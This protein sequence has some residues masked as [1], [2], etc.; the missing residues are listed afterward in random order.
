MDKTRA[1]N[2]TNR[3][4]RVTAAILT[5]IFL[6]FV[7]TAFGVMVTGDFQGLRKSVQLTDEK[8]EQLPGGAGRLDRL[9]ARINGFTAEIADAMW[10]KTELGYANSAFQYALGKRMINTGSQNMVKLNTGHLYDLNPYKD[11]SKNCADIISLRDTALKD[12]PFLFVYEHPTLYAEGMMPAGYEA[13]DASARMADEAAAALREGG[14]EVLDSRDVIPNCGRDLNDLLLVTDQHWSTLA[15]ITMAQSVA[16][17]LNRMTGAKLDAS[18]LDLENLNTLK[19]EKLFIGKYGQRLGPGLVTPDDI[20]EYWPKADTHIHRLTRHVTRVVEEDGPFR[21][22]VTRFEVLETPEGQSWN[23]RAYMLYGLTESYS[24]FTNEAAPD[25]TVL[26]LKDSYGAPIGTFLSLL[27][28]NVVCVD[29]RQD[30]D[31]L[32]TWLEKYDPDAVVMAYSLQMLRD[33]NYAFE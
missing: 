33:D 32:E 28:R 17:T 25:Y 16:D 21:D 9:A 31:P 2:G 18:L 26:L 24:I 6:G 7:F 5:V 12:R 1:M 4:S 11:L 10:L 20:T 3:L 29:L 13:L 8:L 19:H 30:V 27:C 14:V 22:A 23:D 15:A